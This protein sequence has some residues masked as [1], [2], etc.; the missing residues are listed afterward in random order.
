MKLLGLFIALALGQELPDC[1]FY[2]E[3]ETESFKIWRRNAGIGRKCPFLLKGIQ[4]KD[5]HFFLMRL[6]VPS[7]RPVQAI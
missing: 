6:L 1:P 7:S 4:F 5:R 2:A 3:G